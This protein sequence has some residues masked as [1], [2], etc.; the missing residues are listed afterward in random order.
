M[1]VRVTDGR[2]L[3]SIGAVSI[4]V[5]NEA[6]EDVQITR[7]AV[8][9]RWAVGDIIDL[10]GSAADPEDDSLTLTWTVTVQH[11]EAGGGC[12]A[13]PIQSMTGPTA[14]VTAPDHEYP[15][16]LEVSLVA[17]DEL[18][19]R[20]TPVVLRLDP[21]TVTVRAEASPRAPVVGLN[22]ASSPAPPAQT[23][24]AGAKALLAVTSPQTVGGRTYRFAGWSDGSTETRRT[25]VVP[26]DAVYVARFEDVTAPEVV[27]PDT[28]GPRLRML[29]HRRRPARGRLALR[30][31]C[32]D[33]AC[34]LRARVRGRRPV[35]RAL[36]AGRPATVSLRLPARARR[37]LRAGRRVTLRLE[38]SATDAAGNRTR[39]RRARRMAG[40][41]MPAR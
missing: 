38:L 32:P 40:A 6:P 8:P 27:P 26:Q 22:G 20:S 34:V 21:T 30:V 31:A 15:S 28:T 41:R 35:K 16:H 7:P 36:A 13:H 17:T 5:G 4:R 29:S 2:G 18:G 33:E 14:R 1:R 24:I 12:H 11:C 10:E 39:M 9:P 3:R 25:V 23:L 37:A 19:A